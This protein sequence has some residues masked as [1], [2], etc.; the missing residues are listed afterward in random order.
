MDLPIAFANASPSG[1]I[2]Q[3][4]FAVRWPGSA[5]VSD[6]PKTQSVEREISLIW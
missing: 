5:F 2:L 1:E 4:I 6:R 3:D